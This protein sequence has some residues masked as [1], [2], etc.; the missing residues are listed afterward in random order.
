[1][2]SKNISSPFQLLQ[3]NVLEF[4]FSNNE[5][6]CL[7][8]EDVQRVC[9]TEYNIV[10]VEKSNSSHLGAIELTIE[11]KRLIK[12][13]NCGFS[14]KLCINGIFSAP[15]DMPEEIFC[16]MLELNGIAALYSIARGKISSLASLCYPSEPVIIP[17]INVNK[18]VKQKNKK[19]KDS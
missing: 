7:D 18:L 5:T 2:D 11:A 8:N 15:L 12:K 14:L 17:M 3:N 9:N 10:K 4:T 19:N 13:N 16:R 6:I 1:M